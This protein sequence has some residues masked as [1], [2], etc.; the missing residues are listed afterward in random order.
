VRF[1]GGTPGLHRSH[2][3]RRALAD[4]E[5][6]PAGAAFWTAQEQLSSGARQMLMAG[7]LAVRGRAAY[8]GARN[9]RRARAA[10]DGVL[11]LPVPGGRALTAFV[12]VAHGRPVMV[13]LHQALQM[14]REA[15]D[16]QRATGGMEAYDAAVELGVSRELTEAVITLV[17]GSEG[18]A[19]AVRWSP[20][21]GVPEG[22]GPR[23]KPVEFTPGDIPA[24][25]A[26]GARYLLDEPSVPVL[27]TG[28]VVRMR[29]AGPRGPGT[30]RLR[31]LAGAEVPYVRA[32]LGEDAYRIA[33]Q[34]HLAGLP[35]RVAGRLESRGVP[36][37]RRAHRGGARGGGRGRA[38]PAAEGA[39]GPARNGGGTGRPPKG[40]RH[41]ALTVGPPACPRPLPLPRRGE[42]G[43]RARNRVRGAPSPTR[44]AR[45]IR[46]RVIT[47]PGAVRSRR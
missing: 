15:T 13:Q 31:V 11:V 21:A 46:R 3:R 22:C 41:R 18:A 34:A 28:T 36:A 12:P 1:G 44:P 25:R 2:V 23:R 7:A 20:A 9:R 8:H 27:I 14:V 39:G 16:Y 47:V 42:G 26:A 35:I 6:R 5:R 45:F 19:V 24:L 32:A 30:V 29:R 33:G 4:R 37:A 43:G 10:L 40:R 38:G 17:G